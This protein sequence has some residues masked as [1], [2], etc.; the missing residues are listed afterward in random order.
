[1]S[2]NIMTKKNIFKLVSFTVIKWHLDFP[3]I[4][5]SGIYAPLHCRSQSN[6]LH[7]EIN[8]TLEYDYNKIDN[9]IS[10]C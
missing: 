4:T 1:M 2:F 5:L 7:S 3:E 9:F 8:K 10:I 6:L